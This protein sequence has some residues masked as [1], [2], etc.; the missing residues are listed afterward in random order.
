M[1]TTESLSRHT[2]TALVNDKPGVLNRVSSMFR[3][4]GFNIS[5]LAVGQSEQP[6][7]VAHD[8][9]SRRRPGCGGAGHQAPAQADRRREGHRH[10]GREHGDSRTRADTG[11]LQLPD[12]RG[13]YA[14]SGHLPR[15]YR[16]PSAG[17][18]DNRGDRRRGQ[19][20]L[21]SAPAE[22]LRRPGGDAHRHHR[23]EP[24]HDR[25]RR[26]AQRDA[27]HGRAGR[28]RRGVSSA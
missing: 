5:S 24:R 4:R 2:I 11:A 25:P 13:D 22:R 26:A 12:A 18:S 17:L 10:L 14:D 16:G 9:R 8:L 7:T 23:A 1:T 20:R 3:R 27:P 19:D 28:W 15:P 6:A 21:A